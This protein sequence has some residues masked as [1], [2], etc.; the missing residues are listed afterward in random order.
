[1]R[2]KKKVAKATGDKLLAS[3][4]KVIDKSRYVDNWEQIGDTS[5]HPVYPT[6]LVRFGDKD[7]G[8]EFIFQWKKTTISKK[9]QMRASD[10]VQQKIDGGRGGGTE[11]PLPI[12]SVER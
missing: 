6:I 10:D 9:M 4:T 7:A 11:R 3:A 5:Q 1:L 8:E 12:H 2:A